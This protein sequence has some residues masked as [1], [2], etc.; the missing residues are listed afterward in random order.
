MGT[1]IY[2]IGQRMARRATIRLKAPLG[3]TLAASLALAGC[4][5]PLSTGGVS[6]FFSKSDVETT[7]SIPDRIASTTLPV[8]VGAARWPSVREAMLIVLSE[9]EDGSTVSWKDGDSGGSITPTATF[10]AATG[11]PCRRLSII[12]NTSGAG[13]LIF[14]A[15]RAPTGVWSVEPMTSA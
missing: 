1:S 3:L 4:S 15:C 10:V 12:D 6:G 11:E 14:D 9:S 5:T 13:E 7:G 8:L 2:R